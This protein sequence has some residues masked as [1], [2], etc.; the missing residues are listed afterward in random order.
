MGVIGSAAVAE[1][2]PRLGD[3]EGERFDAR[4]EEIRELSRDLVGA[5]WVTVVPSPDASTALR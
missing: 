1:G 2:T 5:P 4:F 3:A